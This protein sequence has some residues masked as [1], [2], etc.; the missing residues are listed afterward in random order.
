MDQEAATQSRFRR[1]MIKQLKKKTYF[2]NAFRWYLENIQRENDIFEAD[3]GF[4]DLQQ[5]LHQDPTRW[6]PVKALGSGGYGDVVL[7]QRTFQD[8]VCDLSRLDV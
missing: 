7:W 4:T 8:K 5:V 2:A 1:N 6:N 3:G